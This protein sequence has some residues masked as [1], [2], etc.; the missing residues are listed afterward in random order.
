MID[1]RVSKGKALEALTSHL[2]IAL[3]EVMAVGD[4]NNDIPLLTTAGLAVAMG[5]A[6]DEVKA[7]ADYITLDIEHNG[8]AAAI[9]K[10]LL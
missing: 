6:P 1:P 8:V 10:F 5:D 9:E 3:D 2:G 7:V 4:G